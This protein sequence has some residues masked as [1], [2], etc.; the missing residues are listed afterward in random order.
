MI[1]ASYNLEETIEH[2]CGLA[3]ELRLRGQVSLAQ[4]A[5]GTGYLRHRDA[6][7]VA[8]LRAAVGGREGL[9]DSWRTYSAE[10]SVDWGWFLEGPDQGVYL[11][12]SRKYSI[13]GPRQLTDPA[14]ACAYFIKGEFDCIV[15]TPHGWCGQR[16]QTADH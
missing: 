5:E 8:R 2:M 12:G 11:V 9:I 7:D 10:K 4:L 3:A 16:L 15:G 6:I 14:E 13:E 1:N